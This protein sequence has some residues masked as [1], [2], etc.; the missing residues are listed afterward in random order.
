MAAPSASANDA[1]EPASRS[2]GGWSKSSW[3]RWPPRGPARPERGVR[4]RSC[5]ALLVG[6]EDPHLT[7]SCC[8][9]TM[10]DRC[11]LAGLALAAV[12]G[13]AEDVR[14]RS[15]DPRHRPPEVGRRGL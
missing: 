11:D 9:T 12:E 15:T 5:P 4:C 3:A 13:S 6:V 7:E 14:L 2:A 8:R 10:T 1:R